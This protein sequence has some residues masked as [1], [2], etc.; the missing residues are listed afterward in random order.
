[1]SLLS[2][3]D[4]PSSL[5]ERAQVVGR[6]LLARL[7]AG[8]LAGLL[9]RLRELR[10][11]TTR[12]RAADCDDCEDELAQREDG[13]VEDEG[14]VGPFVHEVEGGGAEELVDHLRV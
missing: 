1:M 13:E 11:P 9:A 14:W 3:G 7:L 5:L 2:T 10:R 8:L 6:R 4:W 12:D